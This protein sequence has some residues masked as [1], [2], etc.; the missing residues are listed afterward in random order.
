MRIGRELHKRGKGVWV[1]KRG[2]AVLCT[3]KSWCVQTGCWWQGS[4]LPM[5]PQHGPRVWV[6]VF[7]GD[8]G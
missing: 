7:G 8:V 6:R 2:C 3:R 4:G 1:C 5:G